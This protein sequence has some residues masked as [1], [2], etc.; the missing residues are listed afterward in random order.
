[1]DEIIFGLQ[2]Q[3]I[4]AAGL[5]KDDGSAD[6]YADIWIPNQQAPPRKYIVE[7]QSVDHDSSYK[8]LGRCSC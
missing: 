7:T 5:D 4:I 6:V 2:D 3:S 8:E 1:M